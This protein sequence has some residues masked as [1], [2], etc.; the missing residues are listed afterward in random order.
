MNHKSHRWELNPRPL[1]AL[2]EREAGIRR[3]FT[4]IRGRLVP[5]EAPKRGRTAETNDIYTTSAIEHP[6]PLGA[7][8][9]VRERTR[10]CLAIRRGFTHG[11]L[12]LVPPDGPE[13]A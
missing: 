4:L 2:S 3:R 13:A 11:H 7:G 9:M 10:P 1:T 8:S 5:P 6:R 12:D